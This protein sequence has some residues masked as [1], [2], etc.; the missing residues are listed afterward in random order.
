MPLFNLLKKIREKSLKQT[1]FYLLYYIVAIRLPYGDRWMFIGRW[2]HQFRTFV[3]RRLFHKTGKVFGIGKG[4][5]F[6]MHGNLITM[7]ECANIGNHAWIRGNGRLILGDHIMMGEFP[8]IYTQDHKVD[9][10][11]YD[12]TY[13]KDVVIGS[14]VWIGGRVTILKGVTIGDNSIVGAGSV[15]TKDVPENAIVAGN[16]A[17]VIKIRAE[18][19]ESAADL[20]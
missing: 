9:G 14:H 11:G 2:S 1:L 17:K 4:V 19:S 16:P 5:D 20:H 12:G 15:V 10:I 13:S 18:V 8:L 7:G 3:C 6:H